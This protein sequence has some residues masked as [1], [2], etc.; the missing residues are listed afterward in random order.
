[1]QITNWLKMTVTFAVMLAFA[2]GWAVSL[3]AQA[4]RQY[5][6]ART[7]GD[8]NATPFSG[9]VLAGGTLYLS[10]TLGLGPNRQLPESAE[11][12]ATNVLNSVKAQLEV[13]DMTMDDLVSVQ[14]FSSNTDDYDAFNR[15]YRTY[16]TKE[17]PARAFIGAGPLLFGARFEV[18]GT[19]VKR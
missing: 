8:A 3:P 9:A 19:A 14:I 5:F 17:F 10:G 15:V 1:M 18:Q 16:F 6:N 2:A 11:A 13:A 7:P 4:G 12:E